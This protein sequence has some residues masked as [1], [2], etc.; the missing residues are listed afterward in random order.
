MTPPRPSPALTLMLMRRAL[1]S[2]PPVPATA[3]P[4]VSVSEGVVRDAAIVCVK[5]TEDQEPMRMEIHVPARL[6]THQFLRFY[7]RL[8]REREHTPLQIVR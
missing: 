2:P 5:W 8:A 7:E 6:V 3:Y 1:S 4:H